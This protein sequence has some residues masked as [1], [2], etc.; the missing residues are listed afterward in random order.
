MEQLATHLLGSS[1]CEQ[2]PLL[3]ETEGVRVQGAVPE[4]LLRAAPGVTRGLLPARLHTHPL[5]AQ[6]LDLH[7]APCVTV[8]RQ[9]ALHLECLGPAYPRDRVLD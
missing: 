3:F 2:Q 6:R 9:A 8:G 1:R 5:G 4:L 7:V